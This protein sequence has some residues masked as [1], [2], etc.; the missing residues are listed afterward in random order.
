MNISIQLMLNQLRFLRNISDYYLK[1]RNRYFQSRYSIESFEY[2]VILSSLDFLNNTKPN[3]QIEIHNELL[4]NRNLNPWQI[5]SSLK[6]L[7]Y[8]GVGKKGDLSK[9][10]LKKP[11]SHLHLI[12]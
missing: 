12:I 2:Q 5:Y 11:I 6:E 3:L 9:S 10:Q 8:R 7:G 1:N 4:F